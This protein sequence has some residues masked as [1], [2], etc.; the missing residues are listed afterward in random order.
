M[1]E[2]HPSAL[3]EFE[4]LAAAASGK[5]IVMFL[6]YDGTLSPIVEDPDS[7]VMTDEVKEFEKQSKLCS[8]RLFLCNPC[9]I[10]LLTHPSL[11]VHTD[12]GGGAQRGGALPDG[13]R[14]RPGQRQG[15]TFVVHLPDSC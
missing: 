4:S 3:G 6:D 2:K 15:T 10:N 14:E 12:E 9:L 13:D 5:Q 1:Q 11:P 8:Y 7:A